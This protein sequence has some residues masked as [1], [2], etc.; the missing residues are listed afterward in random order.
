MGC[1]GS[2]LRAADVRGRA[3]RLVG[4]RHPSEGIYSWSRVETSGVFTLSMCSYCAGS[5]LSGFLSGAPKA[6]NTSV[7]RRRRAAPRVP[8]GGR[9]HPLFA[10]V[11]LGYGVLC[12]CGVGMAYNILLGYAAWWFPDRPGSCNGLLLTCYGF[13]FPWRLRP[14]ICSPRWAGPGP[15]WHSVSLREVC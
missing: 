6:L 5:L 11:A 15:Y 10:G 9:L 14:I 4:V 1:T 13:S 8:S 2:V 12:G 3:V 7:V